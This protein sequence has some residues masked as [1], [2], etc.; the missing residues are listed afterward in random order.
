MYFAKTFLPATIAPG[1]FAFCKSFDGSLGTSL[2]VQA[3]FWPGEV[4]RHPIREFCDTLP[5]MIKRS[6]L[7]RGHANS[8]GLG[9][10]LADRVSVQLGNF[11]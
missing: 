4:R 7:W 9:L 3:A 10:L 6:D 2:D 5:N 8:K 11:I 1:A